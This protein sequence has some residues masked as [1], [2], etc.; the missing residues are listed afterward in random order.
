MR[1]IENN[2]IK[3]TQVISNSLISAAVRNRPFCV[4]LQGKFD[5]IL[6]GRLV[7]IK[8][9]QD[10]G[11]WN[12]HDVIDMDVRSIRSVCLFRSSPGTPVPFLMSLNR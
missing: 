2:N 8:V 6:T 12:N 1:Q 4:A 10:L 9:L 3:Q 5:V 7:L 11:P